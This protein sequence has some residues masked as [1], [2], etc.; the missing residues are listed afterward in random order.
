MAVIAQG[1]ATI[2]PEA[3]FTGAGTRTGDRQCNNGFDAVSHARLQ[4]WSVWHCSE[5]PPATARTCSRAI[6]TTRGRIPH[7][8]GSC[9]CTAR[10]TRRSTSIFASSGLP[11]AANAGSRPAASRVPTPITLHG[12]RCRSLAGAVPS[13]CE[14]PS[15]QY[16]QAAATGALAESHWAAAPATGPR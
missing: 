9:S 8:R 3:R 10:S 11:A 5:L 14:C 2:A 12:V 16:F 1:N 4:S 13:R 15:M 7:R 6:G